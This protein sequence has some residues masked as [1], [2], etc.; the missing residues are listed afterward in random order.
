M[1]VSKGLRRLLRIRELE[2]EQ[3]RRALESATAGLRRLEQ[4][5]AAARERE[6]QGWRLVVTGVLEGEPV[7]R[8]A[9]ME[10]TKAGAILSAFLAPGIEGAQDT[11]FEAREEFLARRVERRQAQTLVEEAMALEELEER[12]HGQQALDDWHGARKH[13]GA[14]EAVGGDGR[15][16]YRGVGAL[17][18]Q[19]ESLRDARQAGIGD[20]QEDSESEGDGL[21]W[22]APSQS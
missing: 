17:A 6:R 1:A 2:E 3:G 15:N 10:E 19:P 4:Q 5:A 21:I 20:E 7:D 12:R 9:G 22:N 8:L 18:R 14:V 11:V 16:E 13:R